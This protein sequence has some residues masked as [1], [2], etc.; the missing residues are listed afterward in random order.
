MPGKVNKQVS[1]IDTKVNLVE[2]GRFKLEGDTTE[3]LRHIFLIW[4]LMN[5]IYLLNDLKSCRTRDR[6]CFYEIPCQRSPFHSSIQIFNLKEKHICGFKLAE[7]C[8][9]CG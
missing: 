7:S 5:F 9:A 2:T 4:Y 6:N 3:F 1:A 8:R